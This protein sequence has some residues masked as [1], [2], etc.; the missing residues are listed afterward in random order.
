MKANVFIIRFP[1]AYR[2]SVLDFGT[3]PV[4]QWVQLYDSAERCT[5]ALLSYGVLSILE[6][7]DFRDSNIH[8][9]GGMQMLLVDIDPDTLED[10]GFE[11]TSGPN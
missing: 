6:A 1:H 4:R 10:A 11:E 2:V 7:D 9:H 8:T 3:K 5:V